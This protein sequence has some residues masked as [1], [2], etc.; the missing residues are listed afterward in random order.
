MS[1][2]ATKPRLS[3]SNGP[4]IVS[5]AAR[6]PR[7]R[8]RKLSSHGMARRMV[9]YHVT[10]RRNVASIDKDGLLPEKSVG[11]EKS[12]WL[13]TR[14]LIWWAFWHTCNKPGRGPLSKLVVYRCEVPRGKLRRYGKGI[15]RCFETV[16]TVSMLPATAY[17][18]NY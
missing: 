9:L 8:R 18:A 13:V 10:N 4:A 7:S 11:K 3:G 14:S 16:R 5:H 15:W 12:V 6:P 1:T 17:A 2:T